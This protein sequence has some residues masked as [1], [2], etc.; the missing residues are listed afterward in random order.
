MATF[1]RAELVEASFLGE[2]V[3]MVLVTF[4]AETMSTQCIVGVICRFSRQSS[5]EVGSLPLKR[6]VMCLLLPRWLYIQESVEQW[7]VV[8]RVGSRLDRFGGWL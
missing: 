4:L 1:V 2:Q 8:Q 7:L 5:A 6:G 3:E